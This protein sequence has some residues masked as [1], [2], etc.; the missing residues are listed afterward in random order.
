IGSSGSQTSA[1]TCGSGNS[2]QAWNNGTTGK[3]GASLNFDGSDDYV[4]NFTSSISP[5]GSRSI[6]AWIKPSNTNRMGII[7]TRPASASQGFAFIINRN[8]VG[9]LTY[10]HTG[11]SVLEIAAGISSGVWQHVCLTYDTAISTVKLYKN[12]LLLGKNSSFSTEASSSFNGVIGGEQGDFSTVFNGQID[13]V[14]IYNYALTPE[15]VKLDYN[16]GAVR[17]E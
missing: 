4:S 15:Q 10:F 12:G 11:G 9:N 2:A 17:F 5:I 6:C 8:N 7:G 1:G 13:E 16:G 14:K 3:R